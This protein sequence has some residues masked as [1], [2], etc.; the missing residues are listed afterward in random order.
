MPKRGN[1]EMPESV[2][3][4]GYTDRRRERNDGYTNRRRDGS[5]PL[6]SGRYYRPLA[7][8]EADQ[9]RRHTG[10]N[11]HRGNEAGRGENPTQPTPTTRDGTGDTGGV[12]LTPLGRTHTNN[13]W[14]KRRQPGEARGDDTMITPKPA[15]PWRA[16]GGLNQGGGGNTH[17]PTG[18]EASDERGEGMAMR[19]NPQL[20]S[21]VNHPQQLLPSPAMYNLVDILY[22][23]GPESWTFEDVK[24]PNSTDGTSILVSAMIDYAATTLRPEMTQAQCLTL[25]KIAI[26]T[27]PKLLFEF[28][29]DH[30]SAMRYVQA[31]LD[32]NTET[33]PA[34]ETKLCPACTPGLNIDEDIQRRMHT[35]ALMRTEQIQV[36]QVFGECYYPKNTWDI[37]QLTENATMAAMNDYIYKPGELV[38][39]LQR[40][41]KR[42][43]FSPPKWYAL[44][45]KPE[46]PSKTTP[47]N[48]TTPQESVNITWWN[49]PISLSDIELKLG[50]PISLLAQK[51]HNAQRASLLSIIPLIFEDRA[52]RTGCIETIRMI[53][54][55]TPDELQAFLHRETNPTSGE[56]PPPKNDVTTGGSTGYRYHARIDHTDYR[57]NGVWHESAGTVLIR[58]MTAVLPVL[59]ANKH[60]LTL[61]QSPFRQSPPLERR[62]I[63]T[64]SIVS[65]E[66]NV[67]I[68]DVSPTDSLSH[69]EFWFYTTCT[70]MGDLMSA[71]KTGI[72]A[73]DYVQNMRTARIWFKVISRA[74]ADKVPALILGG[75]MDSDSNEMIADEINDRLGMVGIG[76]DKC[77]T[78][79][80]DNYAVITPRT[81]ERSVTMKCIM[82]H[83][84]DASTLARLVET[85]ST[86]GLPTRHL[87]TRDYSFTTVEYPPSNQFQSTIGR[88]IER[89]RT[90]LNSIT[91]TTL[92][93][94]KGIDP[95]FDVPQST[96]PFYTGEARI[97]DQTLA[98]LILLGEITDS[99]GRTMK[100]PVIRL[101]MSTSGRMHLTALKEEA[102]SLIKTTEDIRTCIKIWYP[103][104]TSHVVSNTVS[105]TR[106]VQK[107]KNKTALT[108]IT[109]ANNP[110][111]NRDYSPHAELTAQS[112][113]EGIEQN[114]TTGVATPARPTNTPA[115]Y[116][117]TE[118][119]V[120]TSDMNIETM[121]RQLHEEVVELKREVQSTRQ[122][123][124]DLRIL[125]QD[126]GSKV[127][128]TSR[129]H[130][131]SSG[132]M[133]STISTM[134]EST[135]QNSLASTTHSLAHWGTQMTAYS[136]QLAEHS[137]QTTTQFTD[138]YDR[139][140][141]KEGSEDELKLLIKRQGTQTTSALCMI[142]DSQR[143]HDVLLQSVNSRHSRPDDSH[144]YETDVSVE[145]TQEEKQTNTIAETQTTQNSGLD[146]ASIAIRERAMGVLNLMET[147]PFHKATSGW[148]I[149]QPDQSLCTQCNK[150]GGFL[151]HCDRRQCT[152][153]KALYHP[154]CLTFL[155]FSME[156]VCLPCTET[157]TPN[158]EQD[159]NTNMCSK[160][161]DSTTATEAYATQDQ[162]IA[163]RVDIETRERALA[164]QNLIKT[165]SS[166]KA[167]SEDQTQQGTQER[168][169]PE[170]PFEQTI[171]TVCK[172]EDTNLLFC[173]RCPESLSLYHPECLIFLPKSRQRV[174]EF[175]NSES[176]PDTEQDK[177][178]VISPSQ[179]G[180]D[181]TLNPGT[182]QDRQGKD[183]SISS[184]SSSS[185]SSVSIQSYAPTYPTKKPIKPPHLTRDTL[186]D[187]VSHMSD[188][189]ASTSSPVQTRNQRKA[190]KKLPEDAFDSP[191]N[192]DSE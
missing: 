122:D 57:R 114:F 106:H 136:R 104:N 128:N 100:T 119:I 34:L 146:T 168:K 99:T 140:V 90:F 56:A 92:Q 162:D 145:R 147:M 58:W 53:D 13:S 133:T 154:E 78:F 52:S 15:S 174:C 4:D 151:V 156:R 32:H 16:Q 18:P 54:A 43:V 37:R 35:R 126:L 182:R 33:P 48:T 22:N 187:Q 102:A 72:D 116:P 124:W 3:N 5:R 191:Y 177:D 127:D 129:P 141:A 138:I 26:A 113:R 95:F 9:T 112:A 63:S 49:I 86:P 7:N 82:T 186:K 171:C 12:T 107:L 85:V 139:M 73:T 166:K 17:T 153:P 84:K 91:T 8:P 110:R 46:T 144:I 123:N 155:P 97:N 27:A 66:L 62:V 163:D 21:R 170:H 70:N 134:V 180:T 59:T 14:G 89:Q 64:N 165:M 44:S 130:E 71:S 103:E 150:Q 121:I 178:I 25:A 96:E 51:P 169:L 77:P 67:F 87:V 93:G 23:R 109:L 172:K 142:Q 38:R 164:T 47:R 30:V 45:T 76:L 39:T 6:Y 152:G 120:E 117:T 65:T 159:K 29:K 36:I 175:C 11:Q 179:P 74:E 79:Y 98:E 185:S 131:I 148:Q 69:F 75:S 1:D 40:R 105:A 94:M 137:A 192:T 190:A 50:G 158:Q 149:R 81:K 135:I 68:Q 2:L 83:N 31:A 41:N 143:N 101:A 157:K 88:A 188:D 189:H 125:L 61:T 60:T 111:N 167:A 183:M 24:T 173:D 10:E 181:M 118:K 42:M 115:Q 184:A 28:L 176:T 132:E 160:R 108:H 19:F 161:R 80:I 55:A 20:E